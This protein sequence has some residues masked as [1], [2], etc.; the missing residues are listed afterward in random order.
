MR[1]RQTHFDERDLLLYCDGELSPSLAARVRIHLE[2]CGECEARLE[3]TEH[4]LDAWDAYRREMLDALPPPPRPWA[5]LYREFDGVEVQRGFGTRMVDVVRRRARWLA[6]G[7]AVVCA[8]AFLYTTRPTMPTPVARVAVRR[9]AASP[10]VA[11][12]PEPARPAA[13][14]IRGATPDDEV[15]VIAALHGI[16]AD[17]GDPVDVVREPEQVVVRGV[18][19]DAARAEQLRAA[20]AGMSDV[21]LRLSP[22][23]GPGEH[24]ARARDVI[25]SAARPAIASRFASPAAFEEYADQVLAK[26]DAIMARAHAVRSLAARFP[27]TVEVQLTTESKTLLRVMV[28]QHM[29]ALRAQVAQIDDQL[30]TVLPD[31]GDVSAPQEQQNWQARS[32][33]LFG[34]CKALDRLLGAVFAGVKDDADGTSAAAQL[35][36]ALARLQADLS[37]Q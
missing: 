24:A 16:G 10:A 29:A 21:A 32:E 3:E 31:R 30:R 12:R 17:L 5:N 25:G 36:E 7:A 35:T 37:G 20:L 19:L 4:S 22:A 26:S 23:A 34:E 8:A 9:A 27:P 15:R 18:G 28:E 6:G 11:Q 1:S 13:R 2:T 14:E 33:R